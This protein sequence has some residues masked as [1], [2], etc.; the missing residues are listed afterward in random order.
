MKANLTAEEK[1][2][3]DD[4]IER[5]RDGD[6]IIAK[7]KEMKEEARSFIIQ[8]LDADITEPKTQTYTTDDGRKVL[9]NGTINRNVNPEA[10]EFF[11]EK[12]HPE[13]KERLGRVFYPKWEL[14]KKEWDRISDEERALLMGEMVVTENI[15]TAKLTVK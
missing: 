7:G 15:G 2:Y 14:S 1:Q 6:R 9:I 12:E 8:L 11:M 13:L 4:A 3:L 5:L 10:L